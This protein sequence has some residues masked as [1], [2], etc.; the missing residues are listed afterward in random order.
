VRDARGGSQSRCGAQQPGSGTDQGEPEAGAFHHLLDGLD[1]IKGK[2]IA[3][4]VHG[5]PV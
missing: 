3:K 5:S 4:C 1:Y 2:N